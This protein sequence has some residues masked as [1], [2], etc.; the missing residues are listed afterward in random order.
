[1]QASQQEH[2]DFCFLVVMLALKTPAVPLPTLISVF[3]KSKWGYHIHG[4][5]R[6]IIYTIKNYTIY[7][8]KGLCK[9]CR[10]ISD[11]TEVY[12]IRHN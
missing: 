2:F 11:A 4:I 5:T 8:Q 10:P 3:L 9:Q 1:M 7:G 12:T 6:K